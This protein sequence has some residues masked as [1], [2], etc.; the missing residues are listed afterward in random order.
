M[1]SLTRPMPRAERAR[2]IHSGNLCSPRWLSRLVM[3]SSQQS[4][5]PGG[6]SLPHIDASPPVALGPAETHDH[7]NDTSSRAPLPPSGAQGGQ[8]WVGNRLGR[9]EIRGL[10]G[11]G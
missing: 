1:H 3:T 4:G 10:L 11:S 8:T 7:A 2:F 5:L 6:E 9:Y